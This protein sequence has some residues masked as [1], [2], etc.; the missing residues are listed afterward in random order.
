LEKKN[1]EMP[2]DMKDGVGT[3]G[4]LKIL[5]VRILKGDSE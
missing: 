2:E 4:R 1:K 5:T 3:K